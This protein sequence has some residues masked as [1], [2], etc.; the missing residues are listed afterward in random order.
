LDCVLW[1]LQEVASRCSDESNL[2]S[3]D[4]TNRTTTCSQHFAHVQRPHC[5]Q[6]QTPRFAASPILLVNHSRA[7]ETNEMVLVA[8]EVALLSGV[9][10][11]RIAFAARLSDNPADKFTRSPVSA[12]TEFSS[13]PLRN[14][15]D[16]YSEPSQTGILHTLLGKDSF[17]MLRQ[18]GGRNMVS[19]KYTAV[20]FEDTG[21]TYSSD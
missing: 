7:V 8:L 10:Y 19:T 21:L 20:R 6:L 9:L 3:N 1:S 18:N 11:V 17:S 14:I 15:P 12:Y 2:C 5:S 13:I 16:R 4:G